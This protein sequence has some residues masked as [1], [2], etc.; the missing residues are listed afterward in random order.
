MTRY[1]PYILTSIAMLAFAANSVL[2]RMALGAGSIDATSYTAVRLGSGALMLF[3]IHFASTRKVTASA[4][5][6]WSA[7]A[8][9][10]YAWCFSISYLHVPTGT[11]AL[12]LFAM[13]Q[14]TMIGWSLFK[15]ERPHMLAWI[16]IA[17]AG[18][19]L[20]YLLLPSVSTPP[21]GSSLLMMAAGVAWGAYSLLGRGNRDPLAATA[22][23]FI[24]SLPL[25][26]VVL[27]LIPHT[28]FVSPKGLALACLSGAVS[29]GI[30]YSIW[31]AAL[32]HLTALRASTVQLTV[33][34]IASVGGA[35]LVGEGI[36]LQL[37]VASVAVLGGVY[38]TIQSKFQGRR[39]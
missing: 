13:V 15:G 12:Q 37:A 22:W 30:G 34:V 10:T 21:L 38:L 27:L 23:N 20:V 17:L 29:S 8:L 2:G 18:A 25:V 14:L 24:G 31:Y 19:G 4:F 3:V 16:G 28:V 1:A 32:P 6:L 33:P 35:L 5:N 36:T 11:G 39:P 9:F 26:A 7:L